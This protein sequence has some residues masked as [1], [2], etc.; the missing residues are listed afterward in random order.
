MF[1]LTGLLNTDNRIHMYILHMIFLPRIN[2]VVDSF[3][4]SWNSH[5]IRTE[6]NW[7]P[8]QIW[9]NG[10]VD[11]RNQNIMHVAEL[12]NNHDVVHEDIEWYGMDWYAPHPTD[13]GLSTVTVDD[14]DC[15]LDDL[16]LD[17]INPLSESA[18]FG[19]DLY[20]QA[21][22]SVNSELI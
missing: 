11:R 2:G 3:C 6:K 8:L 5:P 15:P 13:D 12:H 21:L 20:M 19:I 4:Q 9:T 7:T 1:H 16:N 18:S 22:E 14:F 17:H 10:M